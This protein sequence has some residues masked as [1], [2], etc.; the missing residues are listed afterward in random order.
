MFHTL[1]ACLTDWSLGSLQ[2]KIDEYRG[3]QLTQII[4][5]SCALRHSSIKFTELG[6]Y[7][8]MQDVLKWQQCPCCTISHF[9]PAKMARSDIKL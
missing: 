5:R 1:A 8:L 4:F 3:Y 9:L 2:E 7:A 6:N